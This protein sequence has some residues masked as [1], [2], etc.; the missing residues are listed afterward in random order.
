[1]VRVVEI[2]RRMSTQSTH[3]VRSLPILVLTVH[4][5]CNCRCVMCDIWMA[6]AQGRELSLDEFERHLEPIRRLHVQ[7]VMLTGGEPLLHRNL[8]RLCERLRA[9]GIRLT[10]VTT[11]LLIDKHHA[12][13]ADNIDELV[14]SIDGAAD[15]HDAVR[16]VPGAF[17]K[18]E[19]GLDLLANHA[20]RPHTIARSVVQRMNCAYLVQTVQ[21]V[22]RLTVDRLSFLAADVS[23][24]AFNRPSRWD[25]ERQSEVALSP[26]QL[27]L[28][29]ASI[30]AVRARCPEELESGFVAGGLGALWRIHEYYSALAGVGEFPLTRC[31]APW[32]SAVVEPGGTLRPCFFHQ[33]YFSAGADTI[34]DVLNA[35]TSV[36]FRRLL[37]VRTDDTC[38]RCVCSI[39]VAPWADV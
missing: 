32:I 30:E 27:P 6:N 8:W 14:V 21:A 34:D 23:S 9:A 3:Y 15:M 37:D 22:R 1:M 20:V 13:I 2:M 18:I 10:L 19:R 7:R 12:E 38:K 17:V 11:G 4:T 24:T 26:D 16:R 25:V 39:N 35:P 29:A 33:P 5:A 36:S 31:N 28:L